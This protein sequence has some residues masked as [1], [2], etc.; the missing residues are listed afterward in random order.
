[1]PEAR[2]R[3]RP[4]APET[5]EAMQFTRATR[6]ECIAWLE[7]KERGS[8]VRI[9]PPRLDTAPIRLDSSVRGLQTVGENDWLVFQ[10]GE[11]IRMDPAEFAS[12]WERM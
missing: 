10:N 4:P 11:F 2:F 6:D 9:P 1:M 12:M 8:E 5:V 3:R 7:S